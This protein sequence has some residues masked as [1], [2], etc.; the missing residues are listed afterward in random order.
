MKQILFAALAVMTV[1]ACGSTD[2]TT[3]AGTH[4]AGQAYDSTDKIFNYLDGKTMT[5]EGANIPTDPNGF[6][7]NVNYGASSQCYH[8]TKIT[9]TVST[10]GPSFAVVTI[11]GKIKATDG[12]TV[13]VFGVGSCDRTDTTS[14]PLTFSSTSVTFS[15]LKGDGNCFD[16]LANYGTFLQ[17]G[18]GMIAADGKKVTM[19][20]FFKDKTIGHSCAD[21]DVG[22]STVKFASADGGA[23]PSFTGN[24]KQVYVLP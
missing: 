18:R 23:T 1:A 4:D 7:E 20:L 8:S 22:A 16:I 17:E 11:P 6:N 21:G 5:M 3:D 2:T 9:T 24:A 10:N 13:A 12:G 15:N 14:T 19:E